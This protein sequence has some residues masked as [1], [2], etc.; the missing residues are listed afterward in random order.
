M[1]AKDDGLGPEI[2]NIKNI[3]VEKVWGKPLVAYGGM[4]AMTYTGEGNIAFTRRKS[5]HKDINTVI[6]M[7]NDGS[8]ITDTTAI[9]VQLDFPCGIAYHRKENVLVVCEEKKG[10]IV[11]LD[12][13]NLKEIKRIRLEG[14][15]KP[16][17]IDVLQESG[18]L[19]VSGEIGTREP[20]VGIFD[21]HD[22]KPIKGFENP[23]ASYHKDGETVKLTRASG[24]TVKDTSIFVSDTN[25]LVIQYD[26]TLKTQRFMQTR[27]DPYAIATFEDFLIVAN[28]S[29]VD[30]YDLKRKEYAPRMKQA[31]NLVQEERAISGPIM[32]LTVSG[33]NMTIMGFKGLIGYKF[34]SEKVD[35][36]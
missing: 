9:G 17:V 34:V 23:C 3:S 11:F 1:A 24:M 35:L 25:D 4:N 8:I 22:G 36:A 32:T 20:V 26:Q 2:I 6:L 21:I 30:A 33:N 19:V 10:E 12:A 29:S 28:R 16:V 14:L 13:A 15:P 27:D 31:L 18:H 7:G 5:E